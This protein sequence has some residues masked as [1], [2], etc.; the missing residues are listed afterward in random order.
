[1]QY[2]ISITQKLSNC[3]VSS[4]YN[5]T[6]QVIIAFLKQRFFKIK[7]KADTNQ[8]SAQVDLSEY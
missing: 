8:N 1:M 2:L 3:K 4:C 5:F 7:Q 6:L